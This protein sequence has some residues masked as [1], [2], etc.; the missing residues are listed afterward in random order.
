[1][2][3][4]LDID[5]EI[6]RARLPPPELYR[7]P[8][9]A[10]AVARTSLRRG[11]HCLGSAAGLE[12]PGSARPLVLL[13]GFVG[14]PLLLVR[15]DDGVL[16]LLSNSCTHRAHLV[17]E[18][19]G[20]GRQLA[21][22][23]H[24]RRYALDGRC[25]GAPGFERL[26]GFPDADEALP[27]FE[28]AEWRGLL[29]GALEPE[30]AWR[31]VIAP[32]EARIAPFAPARWRVDASLDR[33]F[34]FDANWCLYVE[35]YLEGLHIPFLHP[36]LTARLDWKS[37]R[38]ERFDHATLQVGIAAE[39]EPVFELPAGHP[40]HGSRVGAI[41]F[42]L[43]P[44]T[45]LNFYPWGLSLNVVEPLG[46]TRTRVRFHAFVERPELH[47]RGAGSGLVQV[48]LEDERAALQVQAGLASRAYR[49]GRYAPLAEMG[50]HAFHRMLARTLAGPFRSRTPPPK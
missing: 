40:E 18:C 12:A 48:E 3:P 9:W 37:Y 19:A 1:M 16:R 35:N 31:D 5:P 43:F 26:E 36:G 23:Y 42:W 8:E 30:A 17:V 6:T 33:T 15:G 45:M 49:G 39:G 24:G 2:K 46:P 27:R 4:Q 25:L 10:A 50:V 7:D 13:P 34:E 22:P 29:F 21:C 38:Y 47:D 44:T 28:V 20:S 32:V 14:E 41:Y 11:W